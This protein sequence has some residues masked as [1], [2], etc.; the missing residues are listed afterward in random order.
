ME[1]F[2]SNLG[3]RRIDVV[4]NLK[5]SLVLMSMRLRIGTVVTIVRV[6]AVVIDIGSS[7]G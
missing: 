3:K 4:T 6:G 7:L 5:A 1:H 2:L